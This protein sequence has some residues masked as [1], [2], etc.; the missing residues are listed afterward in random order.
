MVA[1][2]LDWGATFYFE[3]SGDWL[4]AGSIGGLCFLVIGAVAASQ[5]PYWRDPEH[6]YMVCRC[7][8]ATRLETP[9]RPVGVFL[10]LKCG[11][12]MYYRHR[13]AR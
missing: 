1:A 6:A 13:L 5:K 8:A 9:D 10:C 3:L 4:I 7:G 12:Q 2:C 11:N